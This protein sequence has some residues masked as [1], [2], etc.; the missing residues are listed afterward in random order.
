[1]NKL[2]SSL[3][4][5]ALS[6][7]ACA[8]MP[9]ALIDG[10]APALMANVDRLTLIPQGGDF[11]AVMPRKV[12]DACPAFARF[13]FVTTDVTVQSAAIVSTIGWQRGTAGTG[14]PICHAVLRAEQ[15][16][17]VPRPELR[18]FASIQ[19]NKTESMSVEVR[20]VCTADSCLLLPP[21]Q[22]MGSSDTT[23]KINREIEALQGQVSK[24]W[25]ATVGKLTQQASS[26]ECDTTSQTCQT[27]AG[28]VG[29]S[30]K[31]QKRN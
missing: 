1:M 31:T 30:I 7:S 6:A 25:N 14:Q 4:A 27:Q 24:A 18:M 23:T 8:Q 12:S 17:F 19:A 10:K 5:A 29:E 15:I 22:A 28:T 13:R 9:A 2:I 20:S 3:L 26:A 21:G 11:L 16:P